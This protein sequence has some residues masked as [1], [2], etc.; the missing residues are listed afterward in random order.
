MKKVFTIKCIAYYL[1]LTWA[2]AVFSQNSPQSGHHGS[3]AAAPPSPATASYAGQQT[4]A[5]KALSDSE[6]QDLLEGKGMGLAKAAELNGYPG[7]MHVLEL[8]DGMQLT[9]EQRAATRELLIQHKA[10][11]RALGAE[12]V[13]AES[14]LDAAFATRQ[15]NAETLATLTQQIGALQVAV[16]NAHLETHLQQTRLL[17]VRQV[18]QYQVLRGYGRAAS[19]HH[20]N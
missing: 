3:T 20:H 2:N 9:T 19:N 7:P 13:Q 8:A 12:L 17:T 16:R 14:L 6:T 11:A 10:K 18:A 5:I 4:R 1:I 15:I